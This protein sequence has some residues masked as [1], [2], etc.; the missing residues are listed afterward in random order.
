MQ[1]PAVIRA[2]ETKFDAG[3]VRQVDIVDE[4]EVVWRCNGIDDFAVSIDE[5]EPC[6]GAIKIIV[7]RHDDE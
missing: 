5:V 7:G 4:S 6:A 2:K 3:R 1:R